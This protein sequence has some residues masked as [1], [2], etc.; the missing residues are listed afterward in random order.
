[1]GEH[2]DHPDWFEV[3]FHPEALQEWNIA[4]PDVPPGDEVVLWMRLE[5]CSK[6]GQ[7]QEDGQV[8]A[9]DPEYVTSDGLLVGPQ[10]CEAC[11]EEETEA[12][13]PVS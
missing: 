7:I 8:G 2:P 13:G 4:F 12:D 5:P 11:L 3:R 6:C 1:M 9:C 10:L